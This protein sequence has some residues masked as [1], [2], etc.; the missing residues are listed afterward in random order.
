VPPLDVPPLD[1]PPLDVPPLDVPPL[2]V[3]PLD[4]PPLPAV[5]LW[6]PVSPGSSSPELHAVTAS[7]R[8]R[9]VESPGFR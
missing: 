2:D 9:N 1:V 4:V 6:E 7:S 3:P 8:V 5:L